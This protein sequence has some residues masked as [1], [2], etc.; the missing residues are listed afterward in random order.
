MQFDPT[1]IYSPAEDTFLL[2][3]EAKREIKTND[4]VLEIGTGSGLIAIELSQRALSIVATDINPHA[5]M[6]A[7]S[8]GINVVITDLCS[9]V[10]GL[11]DLV[12][13]NAP[14][15]P[16]QFEERIDDWFELALDGG[17]NGREVIERFAI[18]V[19]RVLAPGGRV[20]LLISSLTGLKE[21]SDIFMQKGYS[22]SIIRQQ[23]IEGETLYV[24]KII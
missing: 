5:A 22:V 2:L 8:E 3:D 11:F 15:L 14:Y 23:K 17:V 4:R 19:G 10:R 6:V 12:I 18:Q 24:I 21:V 1:Q 13:F 20:L 7:S 16:T 9:G